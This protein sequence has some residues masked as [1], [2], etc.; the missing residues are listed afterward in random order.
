MKINESGS[1][2]F[3]INNIILRVSD[4]F[5]LINFNFK[6]INIIFPINSTEIIVILNGKAIIMQN[7]RKLLEFIKA[8]IL[9]YSCD[10]TV[11]V[12]QIVKVQ[13]VEEK[14]LNPIDV[15]VLTPKQQKI[16]LSMYNQYK[17]QKQ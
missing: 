15:G 17:K 9:M 7:Y 10:M 13:T 6:N 16:I 12:K 2:Y 3:K 8:I 11:E 14:M 1:T 4:H 5:A